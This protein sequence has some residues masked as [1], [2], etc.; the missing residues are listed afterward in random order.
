MPIVAHARNTVCCNTVTMRRLIYD[1]PH[2][3]QH[4]R[5]APDGISGSERCARTT[6]FSGSSEGAGLGGQQLNLEPRGGLGSVN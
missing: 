2:M 4:S 3:R 1:Q 6:D 5:P